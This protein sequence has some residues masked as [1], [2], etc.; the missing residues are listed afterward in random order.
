MHIERDV[1]VTTRNGAPIS[2][3]VFR[4][5]GDAQVPV[6][7]SMSPYGKDVHW[8][9]RYP[10]FEAADRSEH[11]AWET[12]DPVW[13]ADRGYAV[14]R[15]DTRGT[16]KSPGRLDLF[17]DKDAEDFYDVIEWCGT[18]PW[19]TGKVASSGISWYAM[20]GWRVAAL[21]PP[22]LAALI[23][24]EGLTDFYRD[25]GRQGGILANGG[26]AGWWQQQVEPQRNTDDYTD[27]LAELRSRELVDDWYRE[28][29]PDLSQVT[30]PLL[31][32][33]NWGS[34]HLH[35]RGAIEGWASAASEHKWL[36]VHTGSHVGPYYS[37]WGK[38]LQLRFLDRFLKQDETAMEAVA[39]VQLAIRRGREVE[40][41]D[42]QEWPPASVQWRRLH[43]GAETLQWNWPEAGTRAFPENFEFT[44]TEHLEITGPVALRLWVSH[45]RDDLDVFARLEQFD[46]TGA[47]IPGIGPLGT[48]TPVPAAVG[49]LRASHRELDPQ[50]SLPHRPWHSHH[51]LR[52]LEPGVPTLLE[53]EVW[54]TSLTLEPGHRLQLQLR[55]DDGDLHPQLAHDDPADR[56]C[57][58]GA[59]IRF[60]GEHASHLLVPA[61]PGHRPVQC[62]SG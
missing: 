6:I 42:E 12:P 62:G 26:T 40:W 34:I 25:W 38:R 15:A 35:L 9:E 33:S 36:V 52:P 21:Q 27:L 50:R 31:A 18:R 29:T 16:G 1:R 59:T 51:E 11:A 32:A 47:R 13:W 39:P 49:W 54:P 24:W 37:E 55:T 19:S 57:G 14:V 44:S 43:L 41:R 60:G 45:T 3:D 23:A 5:D 53:I 56:R 7:A 28:R 2:V 58:A 46:T 48:A 10:L 17:A 61:I 8:P 20:M 4:P 22:H 30:V